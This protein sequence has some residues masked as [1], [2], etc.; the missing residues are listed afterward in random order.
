MLAL[1]GVIGPDGA[2]S[3]CAFIAFSV[4]GRVECL[5]ESEQ[6]W[7]VGEVGSSALWYRLLHGCVDGS[8]SVWVFDLCM[9]M[10]AG[11]RVSSF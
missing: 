1:V 3:R 9:H 7:F 10:R 6:K 8:Q 11:T 2:I 5:N 4:G